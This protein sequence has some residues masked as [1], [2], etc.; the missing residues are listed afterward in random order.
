MAFSVS[1]GTTFGI[2]AGVP[3]TFDTTGY[4][5]L[6]FTTV[7]E[8]R[9]FSEFGVTWANASHTPVALRGLQ[10]KKTSRDPGRFTLTMALDTDNA[11]QIL[12]KAARDS[13]TAIY[14]AKFL[15]AGGDIYYCQVLVNSFTVAPG[16]Q[17]GDQMA[18]AAC[19][20][21]TS[22]TDVDWVEKLAT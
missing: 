14:A 1:A 12:M 2:S 18:T 17:A 22:S 8:I 3:S 7:G 16:N 13:A 11:G 9:D 4:D 20:V 15:L 6:S 19:A 5:A 21:T 10:R